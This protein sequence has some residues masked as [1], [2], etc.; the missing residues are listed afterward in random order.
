MVFMDCVIWNCQGAAS[1]EFNRALKDLLRLH[2]PGVL[3]LL[4][5][6]VSGS[7]ADSLCK[8]W[9]FANWV[10]VEAFGFSGGIWVFW[11]DKYQIEVV[12]THP[13]FVHLCVNGDGARNWFL[14]VVYGSPNATLRKMLWQDLRKE[15]IGITAPWLLAGDFNSVVSSD[16][17]SSNRHQVHKRCA[18]FVN[19][20]FDQG[21]IDMGF[22][23]PIYTWSRG[24]REC[25]LKGTRLDR[26]ICSGGWKEMFPTASIVHL[27]KHHSDHSPILIRFQEQDCDN[28]IKSFRF[29]AAWLTHPDFQRLVRQVWD[30]GQSVLENN[31]NIATALTGWNRNTFGNIYHRKK[32]LWARIGGIQTRMAVSPSWRLQKLESKLRKE[33]DVVLFQEELLWYQQSRENWIRS[34]DRNTKFYHA[35]TMVRK[36]RSRIEALKGPNDVWISDPASLQVMVHD[37]FMNLYTMDDSCDMSLI[38]RGYFPALN[39]EQT[40]EIHMRFSA[41]EI[42]Q[43]LFDMAPLKAPGPDG[44]N[45]G[46]YQRMWSVV[47]NSL[48]RFV[49]EFLDSGIMP[50]GINDTLLVL[51]PK[52]M[53]PEYVS[54]FRPISLCNLGYKLITKALTNR[55]QR[56]MPSIVSPN[57]SS[58]VPGRQITDNIIV[59]QEVLHSMGKKRGG[60]GYMAIKIDLE[61]AYDMLSW[62]FIQD[63]LT[64]VGLDDIWVRN[65]MQCVTTSRMAVIWNG[66]R[67]DW[68]NPSRGIRQGDAISPY[69]FVLCIERL[70][71]II[72]RAVSQGAWVPIKL[73]RQGPNLSHLFFADDLVL[74]AEASIDQMN[75]VQDCLRTFCAGSGQKVSLKKSQIFVS[76]NVDPGVAQELAQMSGFT[77]TTHLG[78]LENEISF[79]CGASSACSISPYIYPIVCDANDLITKGVCMNIERLVRRFLWGGNE[80]LRKVSIVNWEKVTRP[81]DAGGLG[82]KRMCQ[83]NHSYLAKIGWR[84]INE[85]DSLWAKVV[86]NKYIHSDASLDKLQS[87]NGASN[88]W[89]GVIIAVPILTKGIRAMVHNGKDTL[90]WLDV[91]IG[92]SPL[93]DISLKNVNMVDMYR[94]ISHYW[95]RGVGWNWHT[96]KDFLPSHIE[97]K[98][99]AFMLSE[100]DDVVDSLCWGK[101]CSGEFSIKTA[102]DIATGY[103]GVNTNKIWRSIWKIEAPQRVKAFIWMVKH[104]RLLCNS[105]RVRRGFTDVP[106]CKN[107]PGEIEDVDHLFRRCPMAVHIWNLLMPPVEIRC[108][109]L[110]GFQDWLSYNL[111]KNSVTDL[112]AS[113]DTMFVVAIWSIWRS[114]ND[115]VFND[116]DYLVDSKLMWIKRYLA[117]IKQ[118]FSLHASVLVRKGMYGLQMIGWSPPPQG[119]VTLNTDGCSKGEHGAA[120]AGGLLR[121]Y[122][123][124]WLKGFF[125]NIGSCGSIEAELWAA[126][127][128]LRLAW[129]EGFRQVIL[130][131]DS[132][133]VADWLNKQSV[134]KLSLSNLISVCR[135]LVHQAWEVKAI[136]VYRERNR[137]TDFLASE[138]L[139]HGNGLTIL[140]HPI[141]GIQGLLWEDFIGVAWPRRVLQ[142]EV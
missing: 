113:W 2:R 29:Q 65:I 120:G 62:D 35:S 70:G 98:L 64:E 110:M 56:V 57:Q 4:E 86:S 7:H 3:G 105:E 101:S 37:Y 1:R 85:K 60:K 114:R 88:L 58:F 6:K 27:P 33:L 109:N 48:C 71:H 137:V 52:V 97:Q 9:G 81:K 115:M 107:C 141:V 132:Y 44:I 11:H 78:R 13:Q 26:A 102:Y 129:E 89:R 121:D 16:E 59:Y 63:T 54:Q 80:E 14:T 117:E 76:R 133:M 83:M 55:L 30:G 99:A 128:G 138:S 112:G 66:H 122:R 134:P 28:C 91:W 40:S 108:Q 84:L 92:D 123:G 100:D 42:R 38:P 75:V 90:F 142:I 53:V 39:M 5:P 8:Q 131:T 130:E 93:F 19:W 25:I 116:K 22:S 124:V 15:E 77:L 125:A 139:N 46:F 36:S 32:R 67:L 45:A 41:E 96:L 24:S 49:I 119:W 21:L 87:K 135:K 34:G 73:S 51:I 61:K 106:F 31:S 103:E 47:G 118:A 17:V 94:P 111:C 68:F 140:Q 50:S 127:H 43:A 18:G 69:L 126:I 10:R 12:H 79:F 23:G 20:I 74:F 82:I 72:N 104:Q 95:R 136:H